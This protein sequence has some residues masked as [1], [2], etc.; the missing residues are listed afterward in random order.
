MSLFVI[1]Y[2]INNHSRTELTT[3]TVKR[4]SMI[5]EDKYLIITLVN[6]NIY[7]INQHATKMEIE[8]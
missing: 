3:K 8:L 7:Y 1:L 5:L 4:K 6:N 2:N